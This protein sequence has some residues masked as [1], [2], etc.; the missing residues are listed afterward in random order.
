MQGI[1]GRIQGPLTPP[2]NKLV[3]TPDFA[4]HEAP[5]YICPPTQLFHS[6]LLCTTGVHFCHLLTSFYS[7]L[8]SAPQG[9]GRPVVQTLDP[10]LGRYTTELFYLSLLLQREMEFSSSLEKRRFEACGENATQRETERDRG[11]CALSNATGS[12][13]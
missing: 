8:V 9:G 6:P 12:L 11:R 10:P 1:Q 5:F 13:S 3:N 7:N 4:A 2:Q